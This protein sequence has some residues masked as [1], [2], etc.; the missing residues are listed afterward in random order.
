[1]LFGSI[2]YRYFQR[3]RLRFCGRY[4]QSVAIA[5]AAAAANWPSNDR[6]THRKRADVYS[7]K[8]YAVWTKYIILQRD[9]C[10]HSQAVLI[11]RATLRR[12]HLNIDAQSSKWRKKKREIESDSGRDSRVYT[13]INQMK[14]DN[15]RY[16]YIHIALHTRH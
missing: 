5:R 12:T 1:M 3:S 9:I 14:C 4:Q 6:K 16:I 15:S 7:G 10:R 8:S 2:F 11:S 13:N